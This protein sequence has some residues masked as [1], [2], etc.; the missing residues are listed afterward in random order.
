MPLHRGAREGGREGRGAGRTQPEEQPVVG[1]RKY[2][3][4]TF[5][6]SLEDPTKAQMHV[7]EAPSGGRWIG[8]IL[9]I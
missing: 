1:F 5:D 3:P 8:V 6:G 7:I 4:K 9:N 2:N